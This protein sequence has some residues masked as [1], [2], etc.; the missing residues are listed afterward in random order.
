MESIICACMN[1]DTVSPAAS[2]II[3]ACPVAA[4]S[5]SAIPDVSM[6]SFVSRSNN[7]CP[8][9]SVPTPPIKDVRAPERLAAT[10]WLAPLPPPA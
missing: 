2:T 10:A 6:F 3:I 9:L 4:P 1:Q 7:C 8:S 5:I